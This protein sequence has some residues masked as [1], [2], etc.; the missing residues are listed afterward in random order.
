M[1]TFSKTLNE[2]MMFCT[3]NTFTRKTVPQVSLLQVFLLGKTAVKFRNSQIYENCQLWYS[4]N[5]SNLFRVFIYIFE[6]LEELIIQK[7]FLKCMDAVTSTEWE[8]NVFPKCFSI[9]K[10]ITFLWHH[11]RVIHCYENLCCST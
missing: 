9:S 5:Y 4:L 2:N 10:M 1:P 6:K 7:I 8:N 3:K 11:C